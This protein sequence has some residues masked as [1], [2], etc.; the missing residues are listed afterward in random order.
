[1]ERK[2]QEADAEEELKE[3][4]KVFDKDQK[5]YISATEPSYMDPE[6]V[7]PQE[8]TS[9]SDLYSYGVLLFLL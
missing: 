2:D 6:Y 1:M 7:L 5:G 3:V 8:L 4:F 9:K